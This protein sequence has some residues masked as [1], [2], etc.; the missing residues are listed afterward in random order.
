MRAVIRL[1]AKTKN[2]ACVFMSA[3]GPGEWVIGCVCIFTC[4]C[5]CACAC[6]MMGGE[7]GKLI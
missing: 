7:A 4:V 1:Q 3:S 6:V 2:H 5:V